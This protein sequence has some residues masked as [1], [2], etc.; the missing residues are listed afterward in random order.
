MPAFIVLAVLVLIAPAIFAGSPAAIS[1]LFLPPIGGGWGET[2]VPILA[3]LILVGGLLAR[4]WIRAEK[5]RNA[6]A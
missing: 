5:A 2:L 3:Q 6:Q 4:V 1:A